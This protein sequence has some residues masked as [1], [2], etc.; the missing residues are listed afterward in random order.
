M[1]TSIAALMLSAFM[2]ICLPNASFAADFR[3]E[4]V[5][6]LDEMRSLLARTVPLG[7]ARSVVRAT[8]LDQGKA[9]FYLHP[10]RPGVE[11]YVYDID[12]CKFYVWR[13][14]ISAN[15]DLDGRLTQV[16]LNGEAIHPDGEPGLQPPKGGRPGVQQSISK[17]WRPRPEASSGER[18]LAYLLY[19][20]DVATRKID[21]EF[22]M[23]A[24]PSRADPRNLGPMH[25]YQA[26]HWRSIIDNDKATRVVEYDGSCPTR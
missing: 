19:D 2:A 4:S 14:N 16:F 25:A 3:F 12:L 10:D 8:F 22:V 20:L 17:A 11:K 15:Y 6:S 18:A 9:T 13:W 21:D 1:P 26:E 24:G 23:G 5:V 7:S